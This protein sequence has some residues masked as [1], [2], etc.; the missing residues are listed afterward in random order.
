MRTAGKEKFFRALLWFFLL[1]FLLPV[2]PKAE[3]KMPVE[4]QLA[5]GFAG[6][7][8]SGNSVPL[9]VSMTNH[10]RD[11]SGMLTIEIPVQGENQA[12]G[13]AL[14]MGN[15]QYGQA[16]GSR[17]Y[18]YEKEISIKAEETLEET[19]YLELPV[20]ESYLYVTVTEGDRTLGAASLAI[21]TSE[22]QQRLLVGVIT[23]DPKELE[24]LDGLQVTLEGDYPQEAFVRAISLEAEDIYPDPQ[25]LGHLDILIADE[26]TAFTP[27]QQ[28]A[29]DTWR[30]EG[31][32]YLKKDQRS[33][34]EM[35]E[36]L[37]YGEGQ[38]TFYEKLNNAGTYTFG[39]T[40]TLGAV[41]VRQSPSMMK[42]LILLLIYVFLA[43]PGIY[44][45][46][47]RKNR[48]K[49]LWIAICCLAVAFVALMAVLGRKTSVRAPVLTCNG[50]YIQRDNLWKEQLELGIQ[51]P[52]NSE[53][54]LYLD[55]DYRLR[56]WEVGTDGARLTDSD[57]AEQIDIRMGQ[58]KNKITISHVPSFRQNFF[59]LQKERRN[60]EKTGITAELLGTDQAVE[61]TIAN[62]TP[63][64]IDCAVFLMKN[65][66]AVAGTIAAGESVKVKNLPLK[67]CNPI[68]MEDFV[69]DHFDFSEYPFPDYQKEYFS[70]MMV[71]A[72]YGL[73]DGEM[74]LFGIVKNPDLSFQENSG[75]KIYGTVTANVDVQADWSSEGYTYCPNL[76]IY[77]T[78][79]DGIF[80]EMDNVLYEQEIVVNY[81]AGTAESLTFSAGD[82]QE[83]AYYH[84]FD[85]AVAFYSWSQ[86]VYVEVENWQRTFLRKELEPYL[87]GEGVLRVQYRQTTR[88]RDG[89]E[90]KTRLLPYISAVRKAD[91]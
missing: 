37:I 84:S 3:E 25:A 39:E 85:G 69:K 38:E 89:Q 62:Q 7:I 17:V 6:N 4:L 48:R 88:E 40:G 15:S 79:E 44:L 68:S 59:T 76:E 51:A 13:D 57:F 35:T 64:T 73:E 21:N 82:R 77:G 86:G 80:Y 41:P 30:Q 58:E 71:E 49:Y 54:Q 81:P 67:A 9:T 12:L 91:R 72:M 47:K 11:F 60:E 26:D 46:L 16:A 45:I 8:K 66:A 33:C 2:S 78:S 14:W 74:I 34:V 61:G 32:Y 18:A 50:S 75:Y 36:A 28:L 65:R 10:G 19:F 56:P 27:D 22:N 31:G 53:Y 23:A 43:G 70:Q 29:I 24:E 1:F 42:Y 52:Y 5:Y 83:G 55:A 20:F 87:S 63:Y 90:Q